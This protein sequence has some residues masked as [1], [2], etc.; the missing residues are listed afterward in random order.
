MEV[1]RHTEVS[2]TRNRTL[3]G[4]QRRNTSEWPRGAR[5]ALKDCSDNEAVRSRDRAW[6]PHRFNRV[7]GSAETTVII[8]AFQGIPRILSSQIDTSYKTRTSVRPKRGRGDVDTRPYPLDRTASLSLQSF[9][10]ILAP[11][12]HSEVFPRCRPSSMRLRVQPTSA[13]L[14]TS[15]PKTRSTCCGNTVP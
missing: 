6:Y 8:A 2:R 13:C 9:K 12:G 14:H 11:R 5:M 4:R 1:W 7:S 15:I 10:A 3:G